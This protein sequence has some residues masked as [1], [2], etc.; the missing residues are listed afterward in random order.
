MRASLIESVHSFFVPPPRASFHSDA[1]L[2]P[3]AVRARS[4]LA[5]NGQLGLT[6][7]LVQLPL[8]GTRNRMRV[9]VTR[10][11]ETGPV[12]R[13]Q[14]RDLWEL[15]IGNTIEVQRVARM[16]HALPGWRVIGSVE[17]GFVY[18]QAS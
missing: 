1:V 18:R 2:L 13:V 7:T 16:R 9:G 10:D 6:N 5:P 17:A 4:I 3:F 8:R 15:N 11:N 12:A 14:V